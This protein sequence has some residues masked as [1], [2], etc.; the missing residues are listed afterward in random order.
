MVVTAQSIID[1]AFST[2][3]QLSLVKTDS[4]NK[5]EYSIGKIT[6][7]SEQKTIAG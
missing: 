7:T 3:H 2:Y 4:N 1:T 5:Q 6:V